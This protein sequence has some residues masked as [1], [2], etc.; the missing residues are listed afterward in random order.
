M[1]DTVAEQNDLR[2][3]ARVVRF[4]RTERVVHWTQAVTFLILLATGLFIGVNQFEA[5][6]G[7]RAVLREIHL[8]TAFFFVFGPSIVALAGNR[9]MLGQDVHQVDRWD[10]D[11]VRWMAHPSVDP[12]PDSPPAGRFN[13]GQKANA[14]FTAYATL[15]FGVTGLILWQNRRFPFDI[16]SQANTIHTYLAYL[17]LVVF[18]G[19]FYLAAIH[20][21]TRDVLGAMFHGAVPRAWA[22]QHHPRWQ[23]PQGPEPSFKVSSALYSLLL[24]VIG[25]ETALLLVRALFVGLGANVTDAVTVEMYQLS[26]LPGTI[27]HPSTGVH[28][29]DLG[30]I[31]W[32][33]LGVVLFY[34]LARRQNLLPG[35]LVPPPPR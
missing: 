14:I 10:E 18:L 6:I 28:L 3:P 29:L 16:V 26:A 8:A 4:T 34:A 12:R 23:Y 17:A 31:I 33:G 30:G 15:A 35:E 13:A 7:H 25:L 19:H 21:A 11:D 22:D 5:L 20:P 2:A 32:A 27:A 24:L 9:R 1:M